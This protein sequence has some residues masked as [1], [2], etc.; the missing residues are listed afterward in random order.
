MR[1]IR[2]NLVTNEKLFLIYGS[3]KLSV[4]NLSEDKQA[5]VV[6]LKEAEINKANK[7]FNRKANRKS[8][9]VLNYKDRLEEVYSDKSYT[10]CT[11]LEAKGV[12]SIKA[13]ACKKQTIVKVS[14][15]YVS[16]G[17]N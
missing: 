16:Y 11:R 17:I 5:F 7:I 15:R 6:T 14:T 13:V 4:E 1:I 9:K 8:N 2:L 12:S 3:K 10:Y